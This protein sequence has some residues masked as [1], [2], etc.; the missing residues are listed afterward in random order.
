MTFLYSTLTL[1]FLL[2][3]SPWAEPPS[4]PS[5]HRNVSSLILLFF[6][7]S[8]RRAIPHPVNEPMHILNLYSYQA[9]HKY[10]YH[11]YIMSFL[12]IGTYTLIFP[13]VSLSSISR[14]VFQPWGSLRHASN[15]SVYLYIC[16]KS[17][18]Y[19]SLILLGV[20]LG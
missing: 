20:A 15:L 7:G 9:Q 2:T 18:T 13:P 8:S 17:L 5:R 19:F 6:S 4:L 14:I 16:E 12:S 11:W 1:L 10:N 3:C